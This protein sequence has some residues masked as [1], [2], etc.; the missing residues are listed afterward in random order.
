MTTYLIIFWFGT[1]AGQQTH[2]EFDNVA[3]CREALEEIRTSKTLTRHENEGHL[4]MK[5]LMK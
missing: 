5:C 3:H 2:I 1:H 4:V